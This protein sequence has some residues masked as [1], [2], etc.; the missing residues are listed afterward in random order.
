MDRKTIEV[1]LKQYIKQI[2]TVVKPQQ[3]ILY[4]SFARGEASEWS[5]ID[6]MIIADHNKKK[7]LELMNTLSNIGSTI[8]KNHLFDVRISNMTDYK[9]SG[10]LSILSEIK[11]EGVLLYSSK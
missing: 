6:L 2:Q 7:E 1:T 8:N 10:H 4:G 3:I 5:D 11:R 9:A